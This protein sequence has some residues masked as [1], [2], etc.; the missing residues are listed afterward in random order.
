[1]EP[2]VLRD[3]KGNA[4][5]GLGGGS[6]WNFITKNSPQKGMTNLVIAED[7]SGDYCT[8]QAA[9]DS[10][11]DDNQMPV[12]MTIRNGNY[13]GMVY[14]TPG[15]DFIHWVGEDRKRTIISGFNND[16]FNSGRNGRALVSV[17]ANDFAV[18]NLTIRNTTPYRGSQA[19]ALRVK[20]DKCVV[21]NCDFYSF[22]DTL[23]LSGRVYVT[24]C[25]IEGDVDFIWGQGI[26]MFDRC[27]IKAMHNGYYL[28]TRNP[29]DHFGYVFLDCKLTAA[30]DVQKCLLARIEAS[31]FPCSAAAF[32]NCQMGTHIP[33]VG[34]EAKGT[35]TSG[36]KFW[37]FQSHDAAGKPVDVSNRLPASKQISAAEAAALSDPAKLFAEHDV[38]NPRL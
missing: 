17:D 27:E 32:I 25:Y 1:M 23:L 20:G 38:W 30:P 28:Q 9:V 31:R 3:E 35:N 21:K 37:E 22:Q 6:P 5:K 18:E 11:S 24:N 15:K 19:E 12:R 7:S 29:C 33:A 14:L 34:W 8:L 10:I 2:G 36:L 26:T 16:R 13:D 4:F